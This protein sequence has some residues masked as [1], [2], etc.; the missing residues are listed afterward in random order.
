MTASFWIRNGGIAV[1]SQGVTVCEECPTCEQEPEEPATCECFENITGIT[2]TISGVG[3]GYR[4]DEWDE[5]FGDD[6]DPCDDCSSMNG[7]WNLLRMD[8]DFEDYCAAFEEARGQ[9]WDIAAPCDDEFGEGEGG[10]GAYASAWIELDENSPT[11]AYIYVHIET[12]TGGLPNGYA[13]TIS[14]RATISCSGV[15]GDFALA[16]EFPWEA[17]D[18]IP[19]CDLSGVVI[20]SVELILDDPPP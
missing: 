10:W 19:V 2:P 6:F 4:T 9:D 13:N 20:D 7:G 16:T 18:E 17:A 3:A 8:V 5:I 11:G 12:P 1:D 14:F 15:V